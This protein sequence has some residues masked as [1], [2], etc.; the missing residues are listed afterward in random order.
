MI[1]KKLTA[2]EVCGYWPYTPIQSNT[3]ETGMGILSV[4]PWIKAEVPGDINNDLLKAGIIENPYYETN[5]V[6]SEWVTNRW[7]VYKTVFTLEKKDK[8][9]RYFLVFEGID[10]KAHIFLNDV[11]IAEHT[12]MC[13][14]CRID[15]SNFCSAESVNN[16]RVVIESAP[17]EMGQ[18]GYTSKTFTQKSRFGY[19]WDFSTRLIGIGLYDEVYIEAV[20]D[21]EIKEAYIKYAD[22]RVIARAFIHSETKAESELEAVLAFEN[23]EIKC[24]KVRINGCGWGTIFLDIDNPQFWWPNG[25]G[26]QPLYRLTLISYFDGEISDSKTYEIG[27]RTITYSKCDN[28]QENSLPYVISVNGMKIPIKGVNITPL[29][30]MYGAVSDEKY[31]KLV[32]MAKEANVNLI[33]VWGG[34]VIEKEIF[35]KLCDKYGILI[36]QD[37]IQS[38]SGI[39]NTPSENEEFLKLLSETANAAV[40]KKRNHSSLAIWCGG[41]ELMEPNSVPV[42]YENKNIDLLKRIVEENDPDRLFLPST[43]SGPRSWHLPDNE[44]NNHDIH[45]PWTYGGTT[46]HYK[47]FNDLHCLLLGETGCDGMNNMS[48]LKKILSAENQRVFA[49]RDNLTWAHHGQMWD[50]YSNRDKEIFGEITDLDTYVKVSQ[51]MQ[52]EGIRYGVEAQMRKFPK[53]AGLMIWQLNE[54]WPNVCCTNLIDYYYNP[55]FAYYFLQNAYKTFHVSLEYDKL[56]YE[57]NNIFNASVYAKSELSKG[58]ASVTVTIYNE[59]KKMVFEKKETVNFKTALKKA[60]SFSMPVSEL[61]RTFYVDCVME[62]DKSRDINKYI[63]F[64]TDNENDVAD[65][66]AV[67][68][69]VNEFQKQ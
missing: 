3:M 58:D 53:T 12:G 64:V 29:D 62:S 52:A 28:A 26:E 18:V 22:K 55:K 37:F 47:F 13:V 17:D 63:F 69:F 30:H 57:K 7:W 48:T 2:W 51:F 5:S 45:G 1:L 44:E 43:A 67:V 35:Y 38:S 36:W 10:Y 15:I 34:G 39:D 4:T 54:P 16:L 19:K 25:Y 66:S 27:L 31:E 68:D 32:R 24:E 41:N 65:I 40:R 6:K 49:M 23:K 20:R 59:N 11:K 61:G 33:R 60:F 42:T 14:P 56:V 21:T 46:G 8:G 9:M 50:T